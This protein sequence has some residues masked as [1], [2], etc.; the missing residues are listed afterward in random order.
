MS[1]AFTKEGDAGDDLPERPV[2][3]GPNYVTPHGLELLRAAVL[4]GPEGGASY[5]VAAVEYPSR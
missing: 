4:E 3:Q 1:R 2:S 5:K